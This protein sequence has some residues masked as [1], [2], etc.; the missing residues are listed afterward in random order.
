MQEVAVDRDDRI[1]DNRYGLDNAT[2]AL[3]RQARALGMATRQQLNEVR[4]I[5]AL[6]IRARL[7]WSRI[8]DDV[9][10]HRSYG[11]AR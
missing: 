8:E 11:C 5:P 1:G 7:G 10:H 9:R 2:R 4:S 3:E 6:P